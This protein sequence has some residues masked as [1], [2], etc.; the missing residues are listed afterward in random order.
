MAGNVELNPGPCGFRKCQKQVAIKYKTCTNCGLFFNSRKSTEAKRTQWNKDYL[1]SNQ[2]MEI[3]AQRKETYC[4]HA[5][6][7]KI[8]SNMNYDANPTR[9]LVTSCARYKINHEEKKA[10]SIAKYKMN[11]EK[12]KAASSARYKINP[13]KRRQLLARYK[14]NPEKQKAASLARYK[15]NPEKK[16]AASVAKYK[17]N[18]EKQKAAFS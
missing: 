11:P 4:K 6:E 15:I 16:K 17:S 10:A 5:E 14:I 1:L 7:F 9:K 3:L 8:A 18:P 12:Q 2:K 13:E